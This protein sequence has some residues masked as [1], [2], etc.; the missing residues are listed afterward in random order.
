MKKLRED[1]GRENKLPEDALDMD[2][3]AAVFKSVDRLLPMLEPLLADIFRRAELLGQSHQAIA[4]EVGVDADTVVLRLDQARTEIGRMLELSAHAHVR[5]L[6][7][8]S[9]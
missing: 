1:V 9:R 7:S 3:R 6:D 8:P 5:H 4:T 2:L